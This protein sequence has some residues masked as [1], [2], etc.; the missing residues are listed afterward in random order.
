[1]HPQLCKMD[2]WLN[3]LKTHWMMGDTPRAPYVSFFVTMDI[4]EMEVVVVIVFLL[5][6]VNQNHHV[7]LVSSIS[8]VII[9]TKKSW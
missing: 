2:M 5:A 7:D 1:M 8:V 9:S 4:G 3:I 6:G